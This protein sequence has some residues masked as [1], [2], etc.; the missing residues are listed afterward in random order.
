MRGDVKVAY[1][2]DRPDNSTFRYRVYNMIQAL[3]KADRSISASF[4]SFDEVMRLSEDLDS[5]DVLVVCRA[6]Y[7]DELN[8]LIARARS[9]GI[10][11]FFD[12]DDLVFNPEYVHFVVNTLGQDVGNP[13]VWDHWF[14]YFGRQNATMALCDEI[15][16][17]NSFL[18]EQAGKHSGKRVSVIPN[19]LNQEQLGYSDL[20]FEAK[21][22]SGYARSPEFHLGYFSGTPSHSRDFDVVADALVELLKADPRIHL[23]F[24][25][26]VDPR[27]PLRP[28]QEPNHKE[29]A[30]GF[31]ELAETHRRGGGQSRP[32]GRKRLYE[33]Q[34]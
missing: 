27:P 16:T 9:K 17:T 21:K 28:F 25:G 8:R 33:L 12:V 32:V 24:V 30:A 18:A 5:V 22:K 34:V 14:S 13:D 10:R 23:K 6:L 3:T 29:P 20:V 11:V 2:Y 1:Y 15:I 7:R 26:F 19:F 4:F 31:C